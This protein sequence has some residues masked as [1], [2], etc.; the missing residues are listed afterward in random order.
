MH[1]WLSYMMR[2]V[3]QRAPLW[4]TWASNGAYAA[5]CTTSLLRSIPVINA[6]S[7]TAPC[8]GTAA[9]ARSFEIPVTR[10]IKWQSL[11][12]PSVSLCGCD[13]A[14][15]E[16]A[17]APPTMLE[18]LEHRAQFAAL[19]PC[20]VRVCLQEASLNRPAVLGNM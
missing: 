2:L 12:L 1:R 15:C 6:A 10:L 9:A 3:G 7:A 8:T 18:A 20:L 17:G 13:A 5:S 16:T 4:L 14:I 19:E 11:C